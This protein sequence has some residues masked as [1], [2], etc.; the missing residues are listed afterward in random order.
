MRE[1]QV[2]SPDQVS[3]QLRLLSWGPYQRVRHFK[4]CIIN[5]YRFHIK[6]HEKNRKTQNSGV[7][8]LAEHEGKEIEFYG[9]LI[10]IIELE[11]QEGNKVVL[12][13]C[14]WWNLGSKKGIS[15]LR[16]DAYGLISVNTAKTWYEDQPYILACQAGQVYYVPDVQQ[17]SSW[18]IVVKNTPRD[19]YDFP[20][21]PEE[22][23]CDVDDEPYQQN[24]ASFFAEQIEAGDH[25]IHLRRFDVPA[26]EFDA[27]EHQHDRSNFVNDDDEFINDDA[28]SEEDNIN[29]ETTDED[30]N[31]DIFS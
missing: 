4:R 22:D 12:F 21:A 31:D 30:S 13:K 11:Y 9:T 29:E 7:F 3:N 8:V 27:T 1:L 2:Q 20:E 10:D 23:E 5:G 24:E 16:K 14:D 26:M 15:G 19:N 17:G 6:D 25:D 28:L 18:K